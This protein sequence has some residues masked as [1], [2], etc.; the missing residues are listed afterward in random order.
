MDWRG[1]ISSPGR[2][3]GSSFRYTNGRFCIV[4]YTIIL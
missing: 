2:N 4:W 3:N 1:E